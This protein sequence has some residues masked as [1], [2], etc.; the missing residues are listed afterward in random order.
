MELENKE[1]KT[2]V[3]TFTGCDYRAILFDPFY[4]TIT[5]HESLWTIIVSQNWNASSSKAQ[6]P[7]VLDFENDEFLIKKLCA[8][9]ALI[10]TKTIRLDK[11][12]FFEMVEVTLFDYLENDKFVS[13]YLSWLERNSYKQIYE[14]L[15]DPKKNKS[16]LYHYPELK[17]KL[18]TLFM[19]Y[20][21]KL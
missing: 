13:S 4:N 12:T 8:Y 21:V 2:F 6:K 17:T 19:E 1:L 10:C 15:L 14:R 18:E 5:A 9:Y 11:E 16:F 20:K 7:K 3:K